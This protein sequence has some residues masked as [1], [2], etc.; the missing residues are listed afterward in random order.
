MKKYVPVIILAIGILGI[1]N[2]AN[3]Q[4]LYQ[5]TSTIVISSS[6]WG[7]SSN[8]GTSTITGIGGQGYYA[9]YLTAVTTV[10]S[11]ICSSPTLRDITQGTGVV[12]NTS[13]NL[14]TLGI[15]IVPV[16]LS[17]FQNYGAGD[18]MKSEFFGTALDCN[19]PMNGASFA[20]LTSNGSP[21]FVFGTDSSSKASYMSNLNFNASGLQF[22]YPQPPSSTIPIFTAFHFTNTYISSDYVS[23][24]IRYSESSSS[25]SDNIDCFLTCPVGVYQT[26]RISNGTGEITQ[27]MVYSY[28][29]TQSNVMN[30]GGQWYAKI[31]LYT[32]STNYLT[33]ARPIVSDLFATSSME[34]FTIS[35]GTPLNN[36]L[37]TEFNG[38][39]F[40]SQYTASSTATECSQYSVG[41]FSST[42]VPAIGCY[43]TQWLNN[44]ILDMQVFAG[45]QL[46]KILNSFTVVFPLNVLTTFN[47]DITTASNN[48]N[49]TSTP[50]VYVGGTSST[51]QGH[52]FVIYSSSTTSWIQQQTGFDYRGFL[53]KLMYAGTGVVIVMI[54]IFIIKSTTENNV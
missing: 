10:T 38:E 22:I 52:T 14:N 11:T 54:T 18:I 41:L 40:Y 44:Q 27:N 39:P 20:T 1:R 8:Y 25:L 48:L 2:F 32:S 5:P 13:F 29:P 23:F 7:A 53:S 45:N 46:P 31:Y 36:N 43:I 4:N 26:S 35:T 34:T 49:L 42:T 21:L 9:F 3:A 15:N 24:N 12:A 17:S 50:S 37:P 6:T 16:T 33:T 30:Q 47:N 19:A 28:M 51:F